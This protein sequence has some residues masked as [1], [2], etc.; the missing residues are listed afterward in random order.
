MDPAQRQAKAFDLARLIF[1]LEDE[2]DIIDAKISA[3]KQEHLELL[4]E[5]L[6]GA[7]LPT[8]AAPRQEPPVAGGSGQPAMSNGTGVISTVGAVVQPQRLVPVQPTASEAS[9]R[10]T[11]ADERSVRRRILRFVAE[12]GPVQQETVLRAIV[13]LGEAESTVKQAIYDMTSTKVGWLERNGDQ[14]V[15]SRDGRAAL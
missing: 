13:G 11:V 6:N 12:K 3:A 5:P 4:T 15:L 10:V 1:R 14:L 8:P 7:Q 2:R 9:P